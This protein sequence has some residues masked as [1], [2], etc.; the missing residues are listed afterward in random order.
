MHLPPRL[1]LQVWDNDLFSPD[2][3][4][5]NT[6]SLSLPPSLSS[7]SLS[8]LSSLFSPF[9]GTVDFHLAGLPL[10]AKSAEE[11]SLEQLPEPGREVKLENLFERKRVKGWWP[12]YSEEEG[13]RTLSVSVM[14]DLIIILFSS[15]FPS[16]ILSLCLSFLS[17]SLSLSL[18][19]PLLLHLS[20]PPG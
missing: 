16:L 20:L 10:G 8:L 14:L 11:C 12:M 7:S 2:D 9:L 19:L 17:L 4:I 5:G 1:T 3:F 18:A 15:F 6:L 13:E